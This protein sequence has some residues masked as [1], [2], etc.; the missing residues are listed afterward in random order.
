MT[1]YRTVQDIRDRMVPLQQAL[2]SA[3][4][5]NSTEEIGTYATTAMALVDEILRALRTARLGQDAGRVDQH[6]QNLLQA[7]E[8]ALTQA[9][10]SAEKVSLGASVNDMRARA[11]DFKTLADFADA[12]VS[13]AL[14]TEL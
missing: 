10:E 4:L 5:A 9:W 8:R 11:L 1:S 2:N 14:G 3:C 7:A 13:A 12:Y 6:D